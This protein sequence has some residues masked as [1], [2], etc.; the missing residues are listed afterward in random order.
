MA[1]QSLGVM[2]SYN[3]LSYEK[4]IMDE[5]NVR[6]IRKLLQPMPVEE[7][8]LK[9]DRIMKVG[10]A[11]NYIGR[12]DK[13]YREDF[14]MSDLY[15]TESSGEWLAAGAPLLESRAKKKY[16]ECLENFQ[17]TELNA[18]QENIFNTHVPK[19]LRVR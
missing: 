10:P 16:L 7:D 14:Y 12:T 5:E 8:R 11:G 18:V 19:K 6:L 13:M 15:F 1:G 2:D 9:I 4:F 3:T 17:P